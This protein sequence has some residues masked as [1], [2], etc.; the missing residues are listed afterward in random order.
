MKKTELFAKI[1]LLA[2]ELQKHID[3][4]VTSFVVKQLPEPHSYEMYWRQLDQLPNGASFHKQS[5][6]AENQTN[7]PLRV[8]KKSSK[9]VIG[10]SFA[11][12]PAVDSRKK[13]FLFTADGIMN[14]GRYGYRGTGPQT[15]EM[16]RYHWFGPNKNG[17][18]VYGNQVMWQK[19]VTICDH[20]R[21]AW[22]DK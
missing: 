8:T 3:S 10:M 4:Y 13:Q 1:K 7:L 19:K 6:L 21:H 5:L 11:A 15:Q 12:S 16:K 22:N 18:I 17:L 14:L 20:A 2:P 9:S